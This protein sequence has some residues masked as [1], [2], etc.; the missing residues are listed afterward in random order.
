[1][2]NENHLTVH[3]LSF[4][5]GVANYGICAGLSISLVAFFAPDYFDKDCLTVVLAKYAF[6]FNKK[7][8]LKRGTPGM[9][10]I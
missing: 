1:L 6:Y 7:V 9:H 10:F 2:C 4:K 8:C 3:G 5:T